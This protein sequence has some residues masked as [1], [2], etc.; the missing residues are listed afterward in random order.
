MEIKLPRLKHLSAQRKISNTW[1][2]EQMGFG[3][4]SVLSLRFEF[5]PVEV[6]GRE[7]SASH[8]GCSHENV[9]T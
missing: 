1:S 8:S 6:G 2:K 9:I 5:D 3:K 7:C 4:D